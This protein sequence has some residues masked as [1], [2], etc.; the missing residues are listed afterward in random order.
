MVGH[1]LE[2]GEPHT[3]MIRALI[4][5]FDGLIL[6]TEGPAY[7]SWAEIFEEFGADLPLSAWEAWVGGSPE[8]FDPCGYLESQ[9][10]RAVDRQTL[11]ARQR[12]REAELIAAE[13]ALPGVEEYI[14][15]AKRLGLKLGLASS[16]DC[17]WVYRHL[18]RLGLRKQFDTIKCADDVSVV[19]PSPELYLSVLEELGLD[20]EEAIALEDSPHGI[21]SAQAA[22]LFCVVVPNSLTR[23]LD[24]AH[25]DLYL[26]SLADMPLEE[27]LARASSSGG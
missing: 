15:Q 16:S 14:A 8:M 13:N 9:V 23:E 24:T 12:E 11:S 2:R 22:G 17:G 21:T 6:D 10:G 1:G 26:D 3:E 4:L 25:A 19:K 20:A 5:D 18:E 27:L 7:Q